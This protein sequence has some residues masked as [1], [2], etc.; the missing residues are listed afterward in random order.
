M[1][2]PYRR[3]LCFL[4][5]LLL[6]FSLLLSCGDRSYAQLQLSSSLPSF[7]Y[8][9]E[10]PSTI[11]V[12]QQ[13]TFE[14]IKSRAMGLSRS[15]ESFC[16]QVQRGLPLITHFE[17]DL[18]N[19]SRDLQPLLYLTNLTDLVLNRVPSGFDL[20]LLEK[21]PK[22][23]SL[24][25]ANS[26]SFSIRR[27][28]R[29]VQLDKLSFKMSRIEEPEFL[30]SFS[31]LTEL[32]IDGPWPTE[33]ESISKSFK[34]L[35]NLRHL[36]VLKIPLF[37]DHL[38]PLSEMKSLHILKLL[39]VG[40][41]ILLKPLE[42]LPQLTE[43]DLWI[44]KIDDEARFIG[45]H[46]SSNPGVLLA[47]DR[48]TL[49][50]KS[51]APAIAPTIR[52]VSLEDGKV[53][54]PI[55]NLKRL[56][57][58]SIKANYITDVKPLAKLTKLHELSLSTL[59]LQDLHPI[60]QLR[61][62]KKLSIQGKML[63]DITPIAKL[64]NLTVLGLAGYANAE[65]KIKT[66]APLTN[67]SRLTALSLTD[68]QLS[69]V[70]ALRNMQNLQ[71]LFLS[72]NKLVNLKGLKDL[73]RLTKLYLEDNKLTT[74]NSLPVLPKLEYIDLSRNRLQNVSILSQFVTLK[75]ALLSENS[76]LPKDCPLVR[77][78]CYF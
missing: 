12:E 72:E 8:L 50:T 6:S 54:E 20:S 22:L 27:I 46:S 13:D 52:A 51:A 5:G 74:L 78:D 16:S 38:S 9:C 24:S 66:I 40:K 77:G 57:K 49:S 53:L 44:T 29:L 76:Q 59:M 64:R 4:G 1:I 31:N 25:I 7:S 10:N 55:A 14:R 34:F 73:N 19:T 26:T 3:L 32:S 62:L 60:A 45:T 68:S 63:E 23:K 47:D 28:S 43:L 36:Q 30:A 2:S 41:K 42:Q 56:V 21:I 11:P 35:K 61:E 15:D 71:S 33:N 18:Q 69:Q 70:A 65:N 48:V 17:L 67:L 75:T 39:V 37:A 58:L